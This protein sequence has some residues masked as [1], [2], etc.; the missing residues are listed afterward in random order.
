MRKILVIVFLLCSLEGYSDLNNDVSLHAMVELV[1][2]D[3]Y[4]RSKIAEIIHV[5][6]VWGDR[7]FSAVSL[8]DYNKLIKS[9]SITI[10]NAEIIYNPNSSDAVYNPYTSRIEFPAGEE[11]FHTYDEMYSE[12]NELAQK[13]PNLVTIFSIGKSYEGKDIWALKI[14]EHDPI[15]NLIAKPASVFMGTHHAREHISTEVPILFAKELVKSFDID[16]DIKKLL[17]ETE[18]YIIPMVNPDGAMHDIVN[19][20]YKYWRKNRRDNKDGSFGVDLNRNYK[21]GFGTGGSSSDPYSDIY[22]GE[23]AFSEPETSSIRDFFL[24]HENISVALSF[25]TYSELIL[26]PWGGRYS[27]VGGDDEAVFVKMANDMSLMNNYTPMQSSELYI[28][29]GDTCDWVYGERGVFCFTFELSPA[30]RFEGGFYPGAKAIDRI[31][32][33]N[34]KPILYLAKS[35]K[36]P[37]MSIR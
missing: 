1:A 36:D 22:M 34:L 2:K 9:D 19:R 27:S 11:K 29:S 31:Y 13:N 8:R 17:K 20:R 16:E 10:I 12:F 26:Y 30:T 18:I 32:E 35:A 33:N 5:D 15:N 23:Y 6:Y 25:H 37:Y 3:S 14:T 28:A 21:Y 7:V 24:S 4:E